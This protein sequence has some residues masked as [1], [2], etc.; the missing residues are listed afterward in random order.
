MR[1][2]GGVVFIVGLVLAAIIALFS[3]ANVPAWA[4]WVLGILGLIVGLINISDREVQLFLIASLAFLLS[5]QA[6]S[7]VF[8]SLTFGW[9]A[10]A[11]FFSLLTV[12]VAPATAIVAIKALFQVTRD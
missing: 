8:T 2:V 10:V 1:N 7:A 11:A 4:V 3:A 12:F 9:E 6:L 5:F